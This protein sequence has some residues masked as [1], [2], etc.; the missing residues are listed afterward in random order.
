MTVK[1]HLEKIFYKQGEKKLKELQINSTFVSFEKQCHQP[2]F[3]FYACK[4]FFSSLL[5]MEQLQR[6]ED[7]ASCWDRTAKRQP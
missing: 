5:A 7:Q 3:F 2:P 6:D 1:T 4:E